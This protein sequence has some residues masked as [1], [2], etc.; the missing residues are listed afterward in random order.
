MN[1]AIIL[2]CFFSSSFSGKSMQLH[3]W[4]CVKIYRDICISLS[5]CYYWVCMKEI[6]SFFIF[7]NIDDVWSANNFWLIQTDRIISTSVLILLLERTNDA[8]ESF[9][10]WK[11]YVWW[12]WWKRRQ[13]IIILILTSGCKTN[14]HVLKLNTQLQRSYS[15]VLLI[16]F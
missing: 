12:V 4:Y 9:F 3:W 2:I 5:L 16:C 15:K 14:M 10:F 11:T 6:R 8:C 1:H 13:I 7:N